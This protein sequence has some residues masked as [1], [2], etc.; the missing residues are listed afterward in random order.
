MP[1]DA[2]KRLDGLFGV[3]GLGR[4]DVLEVS[5]LAGA[6]KSQLALQLCLL[7]LVKYP[8]LNVIFMDAGDSFSLTRVIQWL[9][10]SDLL[11]RQWASGVLE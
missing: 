10:H 1:R 2:T 8:D 11:S 3:Q 9:S 4:G 7:S 6:G 5:G